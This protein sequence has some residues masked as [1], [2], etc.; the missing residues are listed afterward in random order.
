V[1]VL[2]NFFCLLQ[3]V[4]SEEA[5]LLEQLQ[6]ALQSTGS[7]SY[8]SHLQAV[9]IMGNLPTGASADLY[10]KVMQF[11]NVIHCSCFRE[12]VSC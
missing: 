9:A 5:A 2:F 11:S 7:N 12:T 6:S 10:A 4:A 3:V 8:T 1:L